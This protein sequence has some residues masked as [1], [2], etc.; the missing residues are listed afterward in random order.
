MDSFPSFPGSSPSDCWVLYEDEDDRE[1]SEQDVEVLEVSRR[2]WELRQTRGQSLPRP[3]VINVDDEDDIIE[4]ECLV[5]NEIFDLTQDDEVGGLDASP[6]VRRNQEISAV[7]HRLSRV[8]W[9]G[10]SLKEGVVV[11]INFQPSHPLRY[12]YLKIKCIYQPKDSQPGQTIVR[13]VPYIKSRHMGG[14]LKWRRREVA[15]VYD[16]D[17]DDPRDPDV[18]ALIEVPVSE[19][20]ATRRL[21]TTNAPYPDHS[22]SGVLVCRWTYFRHWP[23]GKFREAARTSMH[24]DYE[25]CMAS[26]PQGTQ[27][28]PTEYPEMS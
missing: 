25:A 10:M 28:N 17:R 12:R 9:N 20:T 27:T 4:L 18:Q 2:L 7:G 19:V 24:L 16:V 26:I 6:A 22:E 23:S 21:I 15:A 3:A 13:G 5:E 11:Q 14:L 8:T 1:L